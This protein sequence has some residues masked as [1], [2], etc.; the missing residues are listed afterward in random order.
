MKVLYMLFALILDTE[1]N[2]KLIN[3]SDMQFNSLQEC[4]TELHHYESN[5]NISFYCGKFTLFTGGNDVKND[6]KIKYLP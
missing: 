5:A 4:K 6:S 2:V 3:A 1:G